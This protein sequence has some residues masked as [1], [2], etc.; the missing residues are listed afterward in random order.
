MKKTLYALILAALV[1]L[2][3]VGVAVGAPT[4][5]K[6]A[7]V[8][9]ITCGAQEYL[10]VVNGNGP[11]TPGHIIAGGTGNLI[12]VAFNFTGTDSHGNVVFQEVAAKGGQRTGQQADLITCTLTG[13]FDDHGQT[14]TFSGTVTA[15]KTPRG[16]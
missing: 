12:P 16:K 10:I 15:F 4:N 1:T 5:A 7:E 3:M 13:T 2:S 9:P 11:F 6:N 8:F 14:I